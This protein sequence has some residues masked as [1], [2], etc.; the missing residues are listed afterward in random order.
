MI[1][2]KHRIHGLGYQW[3]HKIIALMFRMRDND[4]TI[5]AANWFLDFIFPKYSTASITILFRKPLHTTIFLGPWHLNMDFKWLN[6][7]FWSLCF[8]VD[9][10]YINNYNQG[11][12]SMA[13]I[14]TLCL[15]FIVKI[16]RC[17]ATRYIC[18]ISPF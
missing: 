13:D 3:C 16:Y 4:N 18:K 6:I 15:I 7:R 11:C 5:I 10:K 14:Q 17:T 1:H 9:C 8:Q 12:S 2:N